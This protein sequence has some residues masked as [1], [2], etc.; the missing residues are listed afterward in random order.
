MW[1]YGAVAF[2][3]DE[4]TARL[5]DEAERDRLAAVARAARPRRHAGSLARWIRRPSSVAPR[6]SQIGLGTLGPAA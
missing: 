3:A 4:H 5:R 6:G 1:A 2:L